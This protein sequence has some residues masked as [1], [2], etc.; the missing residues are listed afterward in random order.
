MDSGHNYAWLIVGAVAA[1][2]VPLTGLDRWLLTALHAVVPLPWSRIALGVLIFWAAAALYFRSHWGAAMRRLR[3]QVDN[4]A[5]AAERLD[6]IIADADRSAFVIRDNL[7]E[8][9]QDKQPAGQ[10]RMYLE[11][12]LSHAAKLGDTVARFRTVRGSL[13]ARDDEL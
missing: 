1:L 5:R 12:A 8:A 6:A 4:S 2:F 7:V 3:E 13:A 11:G 10:A 9:L